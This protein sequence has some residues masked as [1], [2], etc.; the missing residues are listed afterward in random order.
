M[1]GI[2]DTGVDYGSCFFA[3]DKVPLPT[4]MGEGA[5]N[6]TGAINPQHR[7]IVTYVSA[8]YPLPGLC[9]VFLLFGVF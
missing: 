8:P 4:C 3:D 9:P 5:V 7:K 6:A 2:T 1:I